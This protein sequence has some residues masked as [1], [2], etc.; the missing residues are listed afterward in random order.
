MVKMKIMLKH[1]SVF[2]FFGVFLIAIAGLAA[3]SFV[4]AVQFSADVT[5]V[6]Y[7]KAAKGKVYV[8][9]ETYRMEL[10]KG[11]KSVSRP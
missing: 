8:R 4:G 6:T 9:G 2:L 10:V 3:P 5:I 11:D 7:G 1:R